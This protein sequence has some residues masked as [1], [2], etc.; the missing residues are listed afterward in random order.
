M[1]SLSTVNKA[2]NGQ[3]CGAD[4][5]IGKV[6]TDSRLVKGGELFIA[7]KGPN[8]D[9][10]HFLPQAKQHGAVAA[11]VS[12]DGEF[13][14]P[15]VTVSD[16]TK[17][18][19]NLASYWRSTF[20][21]PV[22]AITGS[23]GK[24]TVKHMV[25]AILRE[26]GPGVVTEGNFN[27]HIGLPLTILRARSSDQYFVLEMGMNHL[28][29]I[30]YLSQMAKPTVALITNASA[31]HLQGLGSVTKVAAAKMEI[32]NGLQERGT[33]VLNADDDYYE[34]W[35]KQ[36]DK[37]RC[38]SFGI[39]HQAD[40]SAEIQTQL[41]KT[42]VNLRCPVG[43]C[44]FNLHLA[45]VHN[46]MNALAAVAV[47]LPLNVNLDQIKRGLEKVTPVAGRLQVKTGFMGITIIDDTYN[48]NPVSLAKGV[49]VLAMAK[50]ER[51]LVMGDMA[52][53]GEASVEMH[54]SC[55]EQLRK[56]GVDRLYA[57]GEL[58]RH[59]VDA[60]GANAEWFSD[61]ADLIGSL[62]AAIH[63]QMVMLVKGSRAMHME[64]VVNAFCANRE[65][66]VPQ[67]VRP[68]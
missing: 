21:V 51:V 13:A 48:A 44:K 20:D 43:E 59:T 7:L 39:Q 34:Y 45:G 38:I 36:I 46:V 58:S 64:T 42:V 37:R 50:G 60:F 28:G 10:H 5:E 68:C 41:N 31:A 12:E 19:G 33:A 18:L 26:T 17:A 67:G 27:N 61:H 29:E 15:K 24:T 66:Q 23:N 30:D 4:L 2:V 1:M 49:E 57:L 65:S 8:F 9:G 14:L 55:G 53:L 11:M 56:L 6:V 16:T 54:R 25:G 3:M 22:I 32:F 62:R 40:V 35:K 63:P 52:E 47:T